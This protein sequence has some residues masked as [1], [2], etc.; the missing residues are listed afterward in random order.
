[1][2]YLK[3]PY[4][5]IVY[6]EKEK[7]LLNALQNALKIAEREANEGIIF[8]IITGF[9]P[10]QPPSSHNSGYAKCAAEIMSYNDLTEQW[11]VF[12]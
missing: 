2:F 10:T 1:M 7:N 3:H 11:A 9:I 4:T 6:F 12:S 8:Q 5:N